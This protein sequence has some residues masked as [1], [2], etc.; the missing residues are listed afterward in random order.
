MGVAGSL[1]FPLNNKNCKKGYQ[2][3]KKKKGDQLRKA[4]R[5]LGCLP[6][7]SLLKVYMLLVKWTPPTK[8]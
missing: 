7:D 8:P 3:F 2:L 4:N 1:G 5:D 6:S